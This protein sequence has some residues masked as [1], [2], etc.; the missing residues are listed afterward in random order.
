MA[1]PL[2][3]GKNVL[4]LASAKR[5]AEAAEQFALNNSWSVVIAV[6]DDGGNLLY[7]ERMD[8]APIGSV[9]VAQDKAR[10]SV[11]FKAPT[12]AF[13]AGLASGVTSLLKLDILPFEGGVPVVVDESIVGAVGVSGCAASSQDGEV[14]QAGA[15]WFLGAIA[16]ES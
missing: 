9:V 16:G 5:I 8:G 10:T 12:K 14:A 3:I 1:L 4:T 15:K 2:L 7:L 13:E 6:V 11:I